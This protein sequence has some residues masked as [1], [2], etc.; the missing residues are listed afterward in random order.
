MRGRF[1]RAVLITMALATGLFAQRRVDPRN[2]YQRVIAVVP[3]VGSGTP[4]DPIRAKY[5]PAPQA[6]A[7]GVPG[8]IAFACQPTDDG[9]HFI[10]ELVALD[11]AA[12][13]EVLNDHEPGVL[14]FNKA[15]S[16]PARIESAVR[17]FRR[18]FSLQ[19]FGVAV[20]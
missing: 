14:V 19:R 3:A 13:A 18:D 5:A 17:A 16:A 8:I 9:R 15:A 7:A 12:L 4:A 11:R 10:V 1:L 20:Q 2:S 6:V